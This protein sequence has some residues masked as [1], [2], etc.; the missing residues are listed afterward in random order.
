MTKLILPVKSAGQKNRGFGNGHDGIDYGWY[1]ADPTNTQKVYAAAAGKVVYLYNGGGW[2]NGWGSRVI[3]EHASGVRTAYNHFWA[4]GIKL[5]LGQIVKAGQ[6][7]GMMGNTGDSDGTHLH[8]ELYINGARVNPEPY[9]TKDLPGTS[10]S[11]APAGMYKDQRK[12]TSTFANVRA[13]VNTSSTITGVLDPNTI[14]TMIGYASGQRIGGLNLWYVMKNGDYVHCSS[15]WTP[16]TAAGLKNMTPIAPVPTPVPKP[17]PV[18]VPEPT[19]VEPEPVEPEPTPVD[20]EPT[21]VEPEPAPEPT[22][23]TAPS[24]TGPT[25]GIVALIVLVV[26]ALFAYFN[27]VV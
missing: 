8:F 23:P 16:H 25:T 6:Y 2:G 21:P 4:N 14:Y 3:I 22:T 19:P 5:A 15:F 11:S 17:E 10:V 20:P 24:K 13:D 7:I 12:T 27:G 1:N 9:Y 26:G 18:P